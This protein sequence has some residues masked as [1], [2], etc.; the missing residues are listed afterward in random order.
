VT[1][2]LPAWE[3][4]LLAVSLAFDA[5]AVSLA[6]AAAGWADTGRA[7]FRLAFHFGLFQALMPLLGWAAGRVFASWLAA[8]DHWIA[9]ALLVWIGAG[10]LRSGLEDDEAARP[11][12]P[13]RGWTL[14]ALSVATS[15]DALAVGA[16]LSL[17]GA[18]IWRPALV[19][20][21]TAAALSLAAILVGRRASRRLGPRLEIAGGLVLV[22]LG[23][24]ILVEHLTAG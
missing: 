6:A 9:F 19:I 13:T 2:H 3:T 16:T 20:G 22:G 21:L 5:A 23:V 12:D 10:M 15:I 1:A 8:V 11:A 14:V 4:A 24:K 7:R 17:L 18:S